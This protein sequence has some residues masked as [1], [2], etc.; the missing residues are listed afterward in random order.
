M[1]GHRVWFRQHTKNWQVSEKH[2]NIFL[3]T[4]KQYNHFFFDNNPTNLGA[5]LIAALAGLEMYNF[6]HFVLWIRMDG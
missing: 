1:R 6:P 3:T 5:D 4:N 2:T